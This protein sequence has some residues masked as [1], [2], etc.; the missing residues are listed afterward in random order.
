MRIRAGLLGLALAGA[1]LSGC[2]AIAPSG[3]PFPGYSG[4]L[5]AYHGSDCKTVLITGDSLSLSMGSALQGVLTSSGRCAHVVNAAV[6]G[7]S[8]G[9]WLPR[10]DA[11]YPIDQIV[12]R[13]HP[14][15]V[16]MEHVGNQGLI[17]PYCFGPIWTDPNYEADAGALATQISS[18]VRGAGVPLVWAIPPVSAFSC[19][20]GSLSAARFVQWK[21]WISANAEAITG[22]PPADWRR[23]FGGETYSSAFDFGPGV[24]PQTVRDF[25]CTHFKP[26]G[27]DVAAYATAIAIEGFW[28]QPSTPPTTSTT[29]PTSTTSTTVTTAP[30]S[31]TTS[32]P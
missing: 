28:G 15:V 25:D 27:S 21:D 29:A 16:V 11:L 6:A 9:D 7:T 1:L 17:C 13:Y 22:N 14:D 26:M 20:F 30:S 18:A 3:P 2:L 32:Q 19:D 23:P 10:P 24:G 8:L 4:T 5:S 12:A 31:T